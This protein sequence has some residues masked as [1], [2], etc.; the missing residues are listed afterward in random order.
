MK[1]RFR[2]PDLILAVLASGTWAQ[3]AAIHQ[4]ITKRG[5]DVSTSA[6]KQYLS[7]LEDDYEIERRES[8]SGQAAEWRLMPE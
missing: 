1:T 2:I 3:T 7:K 6:V 5:I 4:R 8:G